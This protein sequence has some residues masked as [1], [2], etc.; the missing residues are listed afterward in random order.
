MRL[1][2]LK[3]QQVE[4]QLVEVGKVVL[5]LATS[6]AVDEKDS[7]SRY[8]ELIRLHIMTVSSLGSDCQSCTGPLAIN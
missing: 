3:K 8:V 1:I 6:R 5:G 4:K 2:W 7:D